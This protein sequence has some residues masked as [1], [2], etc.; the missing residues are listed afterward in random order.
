MESGAL[1]V[2]AWLQMRLRG[3]QVVFNGLLAG[4]G[5]GAR[6]GR[7]KAHGFISGMRLQTIRRAFETHKMDV[8]VVKTWIPPCCL[9]Y[10]QTTPSRP[11]TE[12]LGAKNHAL[13]M[14]R[15]RNH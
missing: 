2:S 6:F 15:P 13:A 3:G 9:P 7:E 11:K 10:G 5:G 8:K 1:N 4:Q 14:V 12:N